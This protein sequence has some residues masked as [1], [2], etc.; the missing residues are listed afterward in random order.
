MK[1]PMIAFGIR[2]PNNPPEKGRE[3]ER[4]LENERERRSFSY[5]PQSW[6]IHI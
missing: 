6:F 3:R 1:A 2:G 4:K 5:I